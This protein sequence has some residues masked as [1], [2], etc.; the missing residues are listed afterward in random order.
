MSPIGFCMIK[1]VF[2]KCLRLLLRWCVVFKSGL[3]CCL[4][5][6]GLK[7]FKGDVRCVYVFSVFFY[8]PM[9]S[10]ALKALMVFSGVLPCLKGFYGVLMCYNVFV[11]YVLSFSTVFKGT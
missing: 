3:K 9:C 2:G 6:K 7:A 5:L 1:G 10:G 4:C 8:G 11:L